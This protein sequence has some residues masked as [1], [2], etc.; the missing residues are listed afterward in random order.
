MICQ[1]CREGRHTEPGPCPTCA[2]IVV[3]RRMD[4]T[5]SVATDNFTL[6]ACPYCEG[7]GRVEGCRGDT[8]CDCQHQT[9]Q[10]SIVSPV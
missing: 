8:W 6:W 1:A 2:A 10:K 7:T 4:L 3:A 5:A 9:G